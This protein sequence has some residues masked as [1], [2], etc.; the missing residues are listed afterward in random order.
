MARLRDLLTAMWRPSAPTGGDAAS[1]SVPESPALPPAE[2]EPVEPIPLPSFAPGLWDSPLSR[3]AALGPAPSLLVVKLDHAGDFVTALP[4]IRRLREVFPASRLTLLCA[5]FMRDFAA[6]TGLFDAV[7]GFDYYPARGHPPAS[8]PDAALAAL[9]GLDLPPIDI[10]IDLRHADDSR[11]LLA[12]LP[13]WFRVGFAGLDTRHD[14]DLALPEMEASARASGLLAPLPAGVRLSALAEVLASA[15][16]AVQADHA[17]PIPL[18]A[19]PVLPD[20]PEGYV[21]L[22]PGARLAIKLWPVEHW[23]ALAE[24]LLD[25]G[26]LGLGLVLTGT[27][28]EE[29]LCAA[30]A[31]GL[32]AGRVVNLA[33]RQDLAGLA[34]VVYGAR[35]VVALDSAPAHM[36]AAL[37]RPTLCL[38]SGLADI[39]SWA[40]AGPRVAVLSAHASCAP[41]LLSDIAQCAHGHGCMT[42]LTPDHA[43]AGLSALGLEFAGVPLH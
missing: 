3:L 12:A 39:E 34:A 21:V 16:R 6:A 9:A 15:F 4:A 28:E 20:F 18:G 23:R 10:A 24:R 42:R 27:A 40:P 32:P 43:L 19:L 22:A 35:A 31:A 2:A 41:C 17:A 33:G 13:V 26:G 11:A 25:A 36:A 37:G 30:I 1:P 5:P 14:L 8:V 7:H 38:F 29:P